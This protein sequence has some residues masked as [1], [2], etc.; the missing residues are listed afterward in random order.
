MFTC[1]SCGERY[2]SDEGR[3]ER[4][5]S[6]GWRRAN[7]ESAK[8]QWAIYGRIVLTNKEIRERLSL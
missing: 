2:H 4:P 5:F 8:K 6:R 7:I 1:L 3:M